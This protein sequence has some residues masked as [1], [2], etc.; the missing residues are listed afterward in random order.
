MTQNQIAYWNLRETERADRAKEQE[1]TRTNKA[2]EKI[3]S[4]ANAINLSIGSTANAETMRA[5]LARELE[6]NRSNLA[7]E[8]IKRIQNAIKLIDT[9]LKSRE[10]DIKQGE[11]GLGYANL[12]E[13]TRSHLANEGL[14]QQQIT[15]TNRSNLAKEYETHRTNLAK[16]KEQNRSNVSN[17]NIA[18]FGAATGYGSAITNY[19]LQ[20]ARNKETVRHDLA[21]EA[22]TKRNNITNSIINGANVL[23]NL[24]RNKARSNKDA[25]NTALPLLGGN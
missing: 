3:K 5:N 13:L 19:S 6:N 1:N 23:S 21:T 15:E 14:T 2:N 4:D 11:L 7:N 18:R 16:E 10:I 25:L 24:R 17:E 12:S 8:E 20:D 22:E 9:A